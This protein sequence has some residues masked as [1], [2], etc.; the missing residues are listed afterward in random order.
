MSYP[1]ETM[2]RIQN[3]ENNCYI[4]PPPS[5][6]YWSFFVLIMSIQT[7]ELT[8]ETWNAL[9]FKKDIN[10]QNKGIVNK[11]I[12]YYFLRLPTSTGS[13]KPSSSTPK[14]K[15]KIETDT[16]AMSSPNTEETPPKRRGGRP[17]GKAHTN[18][19]LFFFLAVFHA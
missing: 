13:L 1:L 14:A 2:V 11:E 15:R 19:A 8:D 16:L 18:F 4:H 6:I 3:K 10:A 9:L 17:K 5:Q 12:F 7:I